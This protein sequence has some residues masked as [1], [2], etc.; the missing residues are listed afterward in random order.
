MKLLI[1]TTLSFSTTVSPGSSDDELD[2]MEETFAGIRNVLDGFSVI[3]HV[4]T[5][6]GSAYVTI[7]AQK[8]VLDEEDMAHL[9]H[10]VFRELWKFDLAFTPLGSH[11]LT[12]TVQNAVSYEF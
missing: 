8:I 2:L 11:D 7:D 9:I 3:S 5:N 4:T 10:V 6:N 1:D 12:F